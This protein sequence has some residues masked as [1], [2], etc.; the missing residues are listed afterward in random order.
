L[1]FN[2]VKGIL[3]D[4]KNIIIN[5]DNI[6]LKKISIA[7]SAALYVSSVA[8]AAGI[9]N[10]IEINSTSNQIKPSIKLANKITS[11]N[12]LPKALGKN[13]L[14][15]APAFID[16]NENTY[17][18][19]FNNDP[20]AQYKGGIT[21]LAPTKKNLLGQKNTREQ[22]YE[23]ITNQQ[24]SKQQVKKEKYSKHPDVIAY[25]K[26]LADSQKQFIVSAEGKLNRDIK[27]LHTYQLALNGV[28]VKI[29][30]AEAAKLK[31][32]PGIS[33]VKK[34][35]M[36]KL[37]TDIG[38]S[39]IGAADLWQGMINN[40]EVKG[41]G[42]TVGIIDTGINTDHISF[43]S[44][45][46]DNYEHSK[47]NNG[48]YLGDCVESPELCNDKL[49]GVFSY[50]DVTGEYNGERAENGEDYNGHGSHT[51][52]TVAGN[53]VKDV[54]LL[55]PSSEKT[56]D[57]YSTS[58]F[59]FNEVSG[60]APHANIISF[61]VCLPGD[62]GD[63]LAGCFPSLTVQAVED[64][65]ANDVDVINYSIGGGSSN[66]WEDSDSQAFLS[67]REAG[68]IVISSAGNSGPD[69]GTVGSP[70]DS[71]WLTSVGAFTH[72]RSFERAISEFSG[73]DDLPT[74]TIVGLGQPG[75]NRS[76]EI[77]Y[78]GNEPYNDPMCLSPL[79]TVRVSQK[80]VLC[81]RGEIPLVEKADNVYQ[82][83]GMGVIIA[84]S[85]P[86][87]DDL[88]N[89]PYPIDGVHIDYTSGET[90]RNWLKSG[91]EQTVLLSA[92]NVKNDESKADN[93]AEFS[94]RGPNLSVPDIIVPSIAAPGVSIYAA[95]AD[96]QPFKS[97][98]GTTDFAFLSGTS[99]AS[100]HVAGAAALLKQLY[101]EWTVSDIH[102]TLQ[103]T[104]NNKTPTKEDNVTLADPFD[105]G[106][107]AVRVDLAAKAGLSLRETIDN[108]KAADPTEGGD[109]SQL[110]IASLGKSLCVGNCSWTRTFTALKAGSY[111]VDVADVST[112]LQVDVS[113]SEFTLVEGESQTI[114]V[115]A[116]VFNAVNNSW[117]FANVNLTPSDESLASLHLPLAAYASLGNLPEK[118]KIKASRNADSYVI[119]DR[120]AVAIEDFTARSYG[121]IAPDNITAQ[122]AQDSDNQNDLFENLQDGVNVYFF[123]LPEDTVRFI[124]EISSST[125]P[126]LDLVLGMDDDNDGEI[127]LANDSVI[128]VSAEFHALETCEVMTPP[129]GRYWVVV[130]NYQGTSSN[131][132]DEYT[133]SHATITRDTE[134]NMNIMTSEASIEQLTPFDI[135]VTYD[136]ETIVGGKLYG[137]FDLGLDA[138]TPGKIGTV[139]VDLVRS[140]DDIALTFSNDPES[141]VVKVG[142]TLN[143]ELAIS[144][145]F[146]SADRSYDIDV[147]LPEQ[148]ELI[149][150][151]LPENVS[152]SDNGFSLS[153]LMTSQ[154]GQTPG[155]NRV[156]N[157]DN[158][159]C[160][161]PNLGQG[162]GY[163][164]LEEFGVFPDPDLGSSAYQTEVFTFF[165]EES[166]HFFGGNRNR[167][168]GVSEDGFVFFDSA[169]DSFSFSNQALPD[170]ALP[171]D[172]ISLLWRDL[173]FDHNIDPSNGELAGITVAKA[174]D[175]NNDN[176]AVI[177]WE[178]GYGF[179]DNGGYSNFELI[180]R[181]QRDL[182]ENAFEIIMAYDDMVY[183]PF[184][185]FTGTTV[186]LENKNS[187]GGDTFIYKGFTFFGPPEI[188]NVADLTKGLV[189][190][191]D[192]NAEFFLPETINFQVKVKEGSAGALINL[193]A[194]HRV[195][196]EYTSE[197]EALTHIVIESNL[198]LSNVDDLTIEEDSESALIEIFAA[199]ADNVDNIIEVQSASG[200]LAIIDFVQNGNRASFKLK[201]N[202]DFYG[203][204]EVTITV[205]DNEVASDK[206]TSSFNVSVTAVNDEPVVKL[207]T[208]KTLVKEDEQFKLTAYITDVDDTNLAIDWQQLNGTSV[209]MTDTENTEL[210][211]KAPEVNSKERLIF[212][213]TVTDSYGAQ[214]TDTIVV[215]AEG[216]NDGGSLGWLILLFLPL[217]ILRRR[218]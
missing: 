85:D 185:F 61:Q 172:A 109:P 209:D 2:N 213:V 192:I 42:I 211:L 19:T 114:E 123:D 101:P 6:V 99:M 79:T 10:T 133:L 170:P 187:T 136:N 208:T 33:K 39:H 86:E 68:I 92:G 180:M 106:S 103:L 100:P 189:I 87:N 168:M 73:G 188:G 20:V 143:V 166:F 98:A 31:G 155:Y 27:I 43:Q 23:K 142:D 186:G 128:C 56:S 160:K 15:K 78:A 3:L 134:S 21:G 48:A 97:A 210:T 1:Y 26:Y 35:V 70:A 77:V 11:K 204:D 113:P 117:S 214:S 122:I 200:Q 194:M 46:D 195:D 199:D 102:S 127:N 207:E 63:S 137:A 17:I 91:V 112:G 9:E 153:Y 177:E 49:I 151:S 212:M 125:S 32:M 57:G 150:S 38:P 80:I 4:N 158:A 179:F 159:M 41:E 96:D 89:I 198:S 206:V 146:S 62:P 64:A 121:L 16:D 116:D 216:N 157:L 30:A 138:S 130:N 69:A 148:L 105:S 53:V 132:I 83:G 82:G 193:K 60:V 8:Q 37:H 140:K 76:A 217:V 71:P 175:T 84:N 54:P 107:G 93:A 126:D 152:A 29:T 165:P 95:Y 173:V 149:K 197:E 145:N 131:A 24:S 205:A 115:S 72:G 94:S 75:R 110:N 36:R 190:C 156:T 118:I 178:N 74:E 22:Q 119:K 162:E 111:Q 45:G 14:A 12:H 183:N 13:R 25:K 55:S 18:I 67:A 174:T 44:T 218:N 154:D 90:L 65:I 144:K 196:L 161:V 59:S 50:S 34:E 58:D 182:S 28:A 147:T 47:P 171:N 167:G 163:I 191:Y 202:Q 139:A 108:F 51:A 129:A 169:V 120:Q 104:A 181:M 124:A 215:T 201:P 40:L 184:A 66:P 203:Q 141:K 81:D 164:N 5:K 7:I 88:H 52:S 135:N 176:F